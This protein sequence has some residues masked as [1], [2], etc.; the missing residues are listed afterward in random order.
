MPL[1]PMWRVV[2]HYGDTVDPP[3]VHGAVVS[4][5]LHFD[6]KARDEEIAWLL[7]DET[8][9]RIVVTRLENRQ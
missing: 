1:R 5:G 3:R 7:A 8:I 2:A 9:G 4:S 6:E